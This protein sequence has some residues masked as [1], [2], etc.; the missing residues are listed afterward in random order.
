MT[1]WFSALSINRK[2]TVMLIVFVAGFLGSGIWSF[3]TFQ[4]AKVNGPYY[5]RIVQGKDLIADILPPPAYIIETYLYVNQLH[6]M[7]SDGAERSEVEASIERCRKLKSE[8]DARH[9]FWEQELADGPIKRAMMVDAYEP[10]KAFFQVLESEYFPACLENSEAKTHELSHGPLRKNYEMHRTAVD[11]IVALAT[12][13]NAEEVAA[14]ESEVWLRNGASIVLWVVVLILVWGLGSF[15]I[16]QT[17]NPLADQAETAAFGAQQVGESA[18]TLSAAIT[19][20]RDSIDEISR[21]AHQAVDVVQ[22][23]VDATTLTDQTIN[24]LGANSAQIG[25]VIQVINSIAGQTN[26]L[27]LNA[28]IE[29]ARAGEAGKGFAVVANEVKELAKATSKATEDIVS[30]VESIQSDTNAAVNAVQKVSQVIRTID[31]TQR[32]IAAAVQEQTAVAGELSKS[33]M[34]VAESSQS[35]AASVNALANSTSRAAHGS[36]DD[37]T[38]AA[39]MSDPGMNGNLMEPSASL[40]RYRLPEYDGSS[41]SSLRRHPVSAS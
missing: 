41:R 23:A 7:V 10:A 6:E 5:Q 30:Q 13:W 26:L 8:F 12:K 35:I 14:V 29:A 15:T 39:S 18:S 21:N 3:W 37:K 32:A 25:S 24:R 1:R 27:A 17:V 31:E 2:L 16:R 40:G 34:D 33:I 4:I 11:Q 20:L 22:V 28:T 19:Q 9:D 38:P 36:R